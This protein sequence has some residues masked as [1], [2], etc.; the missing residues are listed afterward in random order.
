MYNGI[1]SLVASSQFVY[2]VGK[3]RSLAEKRGVRVLTHTVE[4][5]RQTRGTSSARDMVL[6]LALC[7][8]KGP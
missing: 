1:L 8:N 6:L 7:F 4:C 2:S 3:R 5:E